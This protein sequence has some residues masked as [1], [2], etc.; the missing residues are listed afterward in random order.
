MV[1]VLLVGLGGFVGSVLRHLLSGLSQSLF[2]NASFPVGTLIVNTTGCFV[3][4][5]LS[6]LAESRSAFSD[7][8]RTLVFIGLLG[9]YTTFSSFSNESFNLLRAGQRLSAAANVLA[10]V[11]GG[12][13][14]VWVGRTAGRLIWGS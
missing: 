3:I 8:T 2:R 5:L 7:L 14:S 12:L 10:Q 4:G 11:F 9:G 1:K 6:Q 13:L